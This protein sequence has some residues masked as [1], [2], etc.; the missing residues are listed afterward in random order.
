LVVLKGWLIR[1]MNYL[2]KTLTLT[3]LIA[4]GD[5]REI[6][7]RWRQ[8]RNFRRV[9]K[10]GGKCFVYRDP[11]FDT[12]CH[13]DWTDSLDVF[14]DAAGDHFEM[15]LLGDW[16]RPNE[17]CFD[18]GANVGLYTFC[19]A[20][21]VGSGGEVISVDADAFIIKRM[22]AAVRLLGANQIKP[23]H[24]AVCEKK[25]SLEFFVSAGGANTFEQSLICPQSLSSAYRAVTVPALTIPDLVSLLRNV[26]EL[27]VAKVDIEGAEATALRQVPSELLS[28]DGPLWQVEINASALQRFGAGPR[29]VTEIFSEACFDRWL[30]PKHPHT[31]SD[32]GTTPRR[33]GPD[34]D[35]TDS[36]YYNLI[37]VPQGTRWDARREKLVRALE[38]NE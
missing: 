25:G 6:Q 36:V 8:F 20:E 5:S 35:F 27:S 37:C 10:S 13:P 14:L 32:L 26:R 7:R 38:G 1:L 30:L 24:A 3:K 34:E 21:K 11:G 29:D 9:G 12:V 17:S 19:F 31:D 23:V 18:L 22:E 16:I 4:G 33:V 2:R 28:P 15:Q